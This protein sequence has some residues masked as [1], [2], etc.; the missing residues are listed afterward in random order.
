MRANPPPPP[1]ARVQALR[2]PAL[3]LSGTRDPFLGLDWFTRDVPPRPA[4][5]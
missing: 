5:Q 3:F 1:P 4:Q 2:Q